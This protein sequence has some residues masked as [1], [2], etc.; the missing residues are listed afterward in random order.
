MAPPALPIPSP[1]TPVMLYIGAGYDLSPLLAFAP[2]GPPYPIIPLSEQDNSHTEAV[3]TYEHDTYTSFLF[4]D[5]KPRYT[6]AYMVA[7]FAEWT[8]VEAR[9]RNILYYA[10]GTLS[11]WRTVPG[12][13]DLLWFEGGGEASL[14]DSRSRDPAWVF[15]SPCPPPPSATPSSLPRD[16]THSTPRP[17]PLTT[18]LYLFNTLDLELVHAPLLE[19]VWPRVEALYV[20]GLRLHV[21]TGAGMD[22]GRHVVVPGK[23][24]GMD[25]VASAGRSTEVGLLGARLRLLTRLK[26]CYVIVGSWGTPLHRLRRRGTANG[27]ESQ[28]GEGRKTR[29]MGVRHVDFVRH[30][31]SR[32]KAEF[33]MRA[34]RI[35]RARGSGHA[36]WASPHS[37]SSTQPVSSTPTP[38]TSLVEPTISSSPHFVRQRPSASPLIFRRPR[39]RPPTLQATRW[40]SDYDGDSE[41]SF[42]D[43][44]EGDYASSYE[45]DQEEVGGWVAESTSS[46]SRLGRRP[47][48]VRI[49]QVA[50]SSTLHGGRGGYFIEKTVE[51]SVAMWRARRGASASPG[52]SEGDESAS[53]DESDFEE[54]KEGDTMVQKRNPVQCRHR[55][56][57]LFSVRARS[58]PAPLAV[59][60]TPTH[61]SI[62]PH[63]RREQPRPKPRLRPRPPTPAPDSEETESENSASE[64]V[65]G[66][67]RLG[68]DGMRAVLDCGCELV[69][70]GK[71][72][73]I[74]RNGIRGA[75]KGMINVFWRRGMREGR[76]VKSL[77]GRPT[78]CDNCGKAMASTRFSSIPPN[79]CMDTTHYSMSSSTVVGD[80]VPG[81]LTPAPSSGFGDLT[82]KSLDPPSRLPSNLPPPTQSSTRERRIGLAAFLSTSSEPDALDIVEDAAQES[83]SPS[84]I[85]N[86]YPTP[87]PSALPYSP[88]SA[89]LFRSP[90]GLPTAYPRSLYNTPDAH[91]EDPVKPK[92]GVKSCSKKRIRMPALG[93]KIRRQ[94]ERAFST[95]LPITRAQPLSGLLRWNTLTGHERDGLS[96][97]DLP[98]PSTCSHTHHAMSLPKDADFLDPSNTHRVRFDADALA[99]RRL[100]WYFRGH[101]RIHRNS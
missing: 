18:L 100:P 16:T 92:Q 35:G 83:Y 39:V 85:S 36:A 60:Q 32:W 72:G 46:S 43:S 26:R 22:F 30:A 70:E 101:T 41:D 77:K 62:K 38:S 1:P 58:A 90:T 14:V 82:S 19:R 33:R 79:V 56:K 20:H 64:T 8:T 48:H 5:A 10:Q 88:I 47:F 42:S 68:N 69:R 78:V 57:S 28:E 31:R 4:V 94:H 86:F 45:E 93:V 76:V 7:D 21:R 50:W 81:T 54:G 71:N 17:Q 24:N 49:P 80:R 91:N 55:L 25:D 61:S 6:S 73:A 2:G 13:P 29:E 53:M 11:R 84:A 12:A 89:S 23:H 95:N 52:G 66:M 87:P 27:A 34:D 65:Y 9:V 59:K 3:S 15:P 74:Y 63:F 96:T 44:T 98:L 97:S 37:P 40:E 75:K 51:E 67:G 99:I